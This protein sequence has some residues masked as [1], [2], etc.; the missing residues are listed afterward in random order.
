MGEPLSAWL[1]RFES[2]AGTNEGSF[3]ICDV[4]GDAWCGN[5]DEENLAE[6]VRVVFKQSR[7]SL[8]FCLLNGT[9][10]ERWSGQVLDRVSGTRANGPATH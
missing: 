7:A 10:E 4:R 9:H 2:L 5:G 3:S 6:E 8:V 1:T